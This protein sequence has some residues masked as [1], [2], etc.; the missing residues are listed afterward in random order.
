MEKTKI[1]LIDSHKFARQQ[2]ANVLKREP[3]FII[4]GDAANSAEG[5]VAACVKRPEIVLIDSFM[6][7]G[8]ELKVVRRIARELPHIRQVALIAVVDIATIIELQNLGVQRILTKDIGSKVL[9][10]AL[11]EI[12][13]PSLDAIRMGLEARNRP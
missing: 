9:I 1:V 6:S 5:Y 3:A 10:E 12:V 13:Q 7:D 11:R 8:M 4:V 2:I